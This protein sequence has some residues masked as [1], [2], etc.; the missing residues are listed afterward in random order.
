M[1]AYAAVASPYKPYYNESL[2]TKDLLTIETCILVIGCTIK[3]R[4]PKLFTYT[5]L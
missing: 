2:H 5:K 1:K 4:W 3:Q